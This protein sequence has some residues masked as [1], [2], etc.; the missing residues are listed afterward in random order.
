[1]SDGQTP[2]NDADIQRVGESSITLFNLEQTCKKDKYT[3]RMKSTTKRTFNGLTKTASSTFQRSRK[4]CHFRQK[5]NIFLIHSAETKVC[6]PTILKHISSLAV[7]RFKMRRTT[8]SG[9]A[10]SEHREG[11]ARVGIL[12]RSFIFHDVLGKLYRARRKGRKRR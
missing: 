6:I 7:K 4:P 10:S 8:S 1:M 3:Q 11:R 9:K 12:F 2:R 5:V